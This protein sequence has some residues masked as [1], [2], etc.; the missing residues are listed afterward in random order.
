M[1]A[2]MLV[3][4]EREIDREIAADKRDL[5]RGLSIAGGA[6]ATQGYDLED[7]E[8]ESD[9]SDAEDCQQYGP[10][11]QIVTN[12]LKSLDEMVSVIYFWLKSFKNGMGGN[13]PYS[14]YS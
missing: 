11:P 6:T 7:E 1:P 8:D 12:D 3:Q 4:L 13:L 14:H 2:P 10:L 9:L 5:K